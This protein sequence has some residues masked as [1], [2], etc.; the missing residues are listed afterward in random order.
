[1]RFA[2]GL[3]AIL[4][5]TAIV[6]VQ[7][8]V[9]S[10]LTPAE[11]AQ[12]I[13]VRIDGA[14]TGS[15]VIIERQGSNYTVVTNWHVLQEKGNYTV[16]TQDGKQY[17][18]SQIKR[19]PNVDLAVFQFTSNQNYQ[20]A[21]KGDSDQITL[22]KSIY[23]AGFPQGTSDLQFLSGSISSLVRNPKDGYGL[24]YAVNAFPGMSGGPILDEQGKLVGIHGLAKTRPD[25]NA[26]TVY[27]IPLKTYLSLAP[28]AQPVATAPLANVRQQPKSSPPSSNST[29]IAVSNQNAQFLKNSTYYVAFSPNG[30]TV[31]SDGGGKTINIWNLSTGQLTR[32]IVGYS[33]S[34][35]FSPNGKLL[36]IGNDGDGDGNK[37]IKILNLSTGQ[38]IHTLYGRYGGFKS[39]AF[40]PDGK[41]LA[42]GSWDGTIKIWNTSTGQLIRTLSGDSI[43]VS[44]VAF[45]P[46]GKTLASGGQDK[47]IKIWNTSTGQLVRTLSGHSDQV[48]SVAFSP[49]GK[50]LASGSQ[51]KTIKIWNLSTGQVVRTLSGVDRRI[52]GV[53]RRIE[54]GVNSVAISP[55]GKILASSGNWDKT[56]RIW[57]L[58][59]GQVIRTL[60]GDSDRVTSVAFN[61]DGK[62]L[63]SGGDN[64]IKIWNLATGQEI[65]ILKSHTG[66]VNLVAFSRDGRTLANGSSDA[67]IKIWRL[68]E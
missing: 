34:V 26:T 29:R 28:S 35:A 2:G 40:S 52:E 1:M 30:K 11:V 6:M 24:V 59:T 51:D 5:G 50:I 22:G 4:L 16:Y 55:D 15:G 23:V 3:P 7:V 58:S 44:S 53:D 56:I 62:I 68:S 65:S 17:T 36:A 10:A 9:A 60:S 48:N 67:T 61:P 8:Q 19:L 13:T 43:N 18:I 20:V 64:G 46:D 32:P 41:I 33:L 12:Q 54:E 45:S 39:V 14:N 47:T 21:Q 63:A 38:I 37:T 57:N 31:V 49:D 27:G 25:T 66:L 42:S